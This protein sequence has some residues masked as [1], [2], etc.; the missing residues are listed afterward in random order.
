MMKQRTHKLACIFGLLML[1]V[2]MHPRAGAEIANKLVAVVDDDVITLFELHKKMKELSGFDPLTVKEKS[3]IEYNNIREKVLEK[4]IDAKI[5][6]K[7][8]R[9]LNIRIDDREIDAAL[10]NMKRNNRWTKDD[11]ES[12]LQARGL[13]EEEYRQVVAE[14]LQR[15]RLIDVEVKSKI[16]IRDEQIEEYYNEHKDRFHREKGVELATLFM[17]RGSPRNSLEGLTLEQKGEK[18]LEAL[19]GGGNF[20]Q[21]V[22]RYSDGPGA[23]EGGYLGTLDPAQ[24]EPEIRGLIEKTPEG[25]YCDLIIKPNGI[26]I[27]KVLGKSDGGIMPLERAREAIRST[28]FKEEVNRRYEAWIEELRKTSYTKVL[29]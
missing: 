2:L 29:L 4:L 20:A 28:L 1:P 19:R 17:L 12:M 24:L 3:P 8:A 22:K 18:I 10:E 21:M 9:E 14:D 6:D 23:D 25:G 7:K 16:I 5:A 26:Q 15:F 11:F 27:I 13:T